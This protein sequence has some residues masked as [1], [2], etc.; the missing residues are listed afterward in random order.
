MEETEDREVGFLTFPFPPDS[1]V[2][3]AMEKKVQ[4]LL[5]AQIGS[6]PALTQV[7]LL[8]SL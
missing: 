5:R 3:D 8:R 4:M 7:V 1:A 6:P 2:A